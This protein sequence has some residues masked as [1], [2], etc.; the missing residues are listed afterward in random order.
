MEKQ[1]LEKCILD[2]LSQRQ[3]AYNL[4]CSQTT[5]KYWLKKHGLT[6]KAEKLVDEKFCPR[7]STI[8][9][10]SDFYKRTNRENYGGY[11]KSCS[12]SYHG[13]RI[14]KVKLLMINYKGGKCIDCNLSKDDV[15][16]S[17]FEFHHLDPD[18]KDDN[19]SKIMFQKWA[20]IENELDKCVL[21]CANCHRIRH[22]EIEGW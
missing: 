10:L 3:I 18:L 19:W 15:H 12:N 13:E 20:K 2:G 4:V 7:C 5:V 6:T 1:V 8:K 16:Q 17:V 9:P 11:C 14:K 21:L 22:A